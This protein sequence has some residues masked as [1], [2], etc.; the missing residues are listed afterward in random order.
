M[1]GA[2]RLTGVPEAPIDPAVD[3]TL[4]VPVA[5]LTFNPPEKLPALLMLPADVRLIVFV[6]ATVPTEPSSDS[7]PPVAVRLIV[8]PF[9]DAAAVEPS[10]L[11]AVRV[12][13]PAAAEL[14]VTLVVPAKLSETTTFCPAPVAF[15]DRFGAFNVSAV[16]MT[17][18]EPAVEVRLTVPVTPLTVSAP[19]RLPALVMELCELKLIVSVP[20][21]PTAPCSPRAPVAAVRLIVVPPIFAAAAELRLPL[22]LNENTFAA[23]ELLDTLVPPALVPLM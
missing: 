14:V 4:I 5:A 17:P 23:D 7:E 13:V 8:D 10:P 1:F 19:D 18:I 9:I 15:A 22:V 12:N 16:P 3:V 6:P 11:D 20:A 21:V 2:G